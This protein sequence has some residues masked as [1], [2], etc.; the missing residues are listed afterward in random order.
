MPH[1]PAPQ[2][3]GMRRAMIEMLNRLEPS[4]NEGFAARVSRFRDENDGFKRDDSTLHALL[5]VWDVIRHGSP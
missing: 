1:D 2:L 5:G 3:D 4:R